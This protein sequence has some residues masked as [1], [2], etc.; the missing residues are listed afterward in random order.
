MSKN[1][2]IMLSTIR[3]F[4][5]ILN[6]KQK[7][8]CVLAFFVI[9]FTA[10]LEMLGISVLIPF[11]SVILV[12]EEIMNNVIIQNIVSILEIDNQTQLLILMGVG[13]AIIYL[14]KNACLLFSSYYRLR[15]ENG[16]QKN[17][18]VFM[19]SSYLRRPYVELLNINTAEVL[20]GIGND[21]TGVYYII[22]SFFQILAN[23]ITIL[24][25]V[26]FLI[27]TDF[28]M[29]ICLLIIALFCVLLLILLMRKKISHSGKVFN[30]TMYETSKYAAQAMG[31]LKEILV[32]NRR[33]KFTEMYEEACEN[34]RKAQLNYR[35]LQSSPTPIIES[36]FVSGLIGAMCIE[37]VL[38]VNM[39]NIIP[40]LATFGLAAIRIMPLVSGITSSMTNVI[41]YIP[42]FNNAYYNIDKAK[43]YQKNCFKDAG[44]NS[45]LSFKKEIKIDNVVWK[46]AGAEYAVLNHISMSIKKG[47]SIALIGESGSGKTTLADAILGLIRPDSGRILAD[48]NDIYAAPLHWAKVVG[49]VPQMVYLLDD[50]IRNNILFGSQ[51]ED[52][53]QIWRALEQAQLKEFVEALPEGLDS[54]VGER[55]VKLSGGQR[56]RIAIARALYTNP[57]LLVL[58]EATSALDTETEE[59]VMEAIENL[60]GKKTLLIIAHRLSTV[61]NCD[62]IYELSNGNIELK[63]K[64]EIYCNHV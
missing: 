7:R 32:L 13:I 46:Y 34:Q 2:K 11:L 45:R 64:K 62:K 40:Q 56:Q 30:R 1:Y 14:L 22:Q 25:I 61:R 63:T 26:V 19:L 31:G 49:Y 51:Y 28:I 35:F 27:T 47:E 41:Y 42:S 6:K 24:L 57:E 16:I 5:I 58:D 10:F 48:G 44:S 37:A 43:K 36:L 15:I 60:Q 20:R 33:N 29:S 4:G 9:L 8:Q 18:S 55:G 59:T 21:V 54:I 50:T 12:P 52:D 38:G 17:L 23:A 53:I 3:K 39:I